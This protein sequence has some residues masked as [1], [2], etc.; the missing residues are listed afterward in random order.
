[1]LVSRHGLGPARPTTRVYKSYSTTFSA[2]ETPVSEGGNWVNSA[3]DWT[4][5]DLASGIAFGTQAGGGFDDS[6]ADLV[7][8]GFG[9]DVQI[10]TTIFKGTTSGTQEI[11]HH[12]RATHSAHVANRYEVNVAHDGS[13]F[14]AYQWPGP[15]GTAVGDFR[16]LA[17]ETGGV[18]FTVPGG[19]VNNGDVIRTRI[20]GNVI[21]GWI[22][23]GAGFVL[24]GT[25]TDTAGANGGAAL[26]SGN[27]GMGFFKTSGSGAMN[28]FGF[29]DFSVT[30]I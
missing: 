12:L 6:F 24:V 25:W 21:T 2:T 10:D 14:N 29:T 26:I 28:Q 4:L 27:V 5:V 20:K 11:E 7:L 9:P 30:E 23:R 3:I 17:T 13:Y 22:N 1:M 18:Q 15:L 19:A 16:P 8:P